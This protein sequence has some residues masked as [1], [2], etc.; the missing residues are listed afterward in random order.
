MST[1]SDL[2]VVVSRSEAFAVP[3]E[4]ATSDAVLVTSQ[5]EDTL[6]GFAAPQLNMG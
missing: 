2:S 4:T 1:H 5:G 3:G 6:P